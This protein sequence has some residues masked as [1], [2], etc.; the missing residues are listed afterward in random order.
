MSFQW[1]WTNCLALTES[2]S[3]Y[4][5][6]VSQRCQPCISLRLCLVY[7]ETQVIGQSY[8]V[9]NGLSIT[10]RTS[11]FQ[12]L[13]LPPQSLS[14]DSEHFI[15]FKLTLN[16]HFLFK[17]STYSGIAGDSGVSIL[18]KINGTPL[19]IAWDWTKM[20]IAGRNS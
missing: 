2:K 11:H 13:T 5:L 3:R 4:R 10:W 19:A 7:D 15:S 20:S 17:W 12:Y 6:A 14:I 16:I 1:Q 9:W 18:C 8:L